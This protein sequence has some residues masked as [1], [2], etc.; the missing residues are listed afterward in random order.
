[1]A[2]KQRSLEAQR[3]AGIAQVMTEAPN[4]VPLSGHSLYRKYHSGRL[5]AYGCP[6]TVDIDHLQYQYKNDWPILQK[7]SAA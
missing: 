3:L 7:D 2:K 4:W 1:M 6:L 5:D